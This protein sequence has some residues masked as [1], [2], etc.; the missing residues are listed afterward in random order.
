MNN[1]YPLKHW[2][3]TLAIAPLLM[4]AYDFATGSVFF[5]GRY[6]DVLWFSFIFSIPVFIVY[7]GLFYLLAKKQRPLY[8]TKIILSLCISCIAF[9]T[10]SM[11]GRGVIDLFPVYAI[12]ITISSFLF[13]P[14]QLKESL[15][16]WENQKQGQ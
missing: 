15:P 2:L 14:L 8:A 13:N 5:W 4:A 11:I 3:A 16:A 1:Y 10:L 6:F 9:I 12:A 7:I